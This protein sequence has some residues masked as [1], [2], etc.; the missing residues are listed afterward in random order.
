[1]FSRFVQ[2]GMSYMAFWEL[3]WLMERHG[4]FVKKWTGK[5]L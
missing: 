5:E 3:F 4:E 2:F 1:M